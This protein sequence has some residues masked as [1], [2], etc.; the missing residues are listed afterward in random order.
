MPGEARFSRARS[1]ASRLHDLPHEILTAEQITSRFPA[2]R[3]PTAVSGV[4][5]PDGGFLD[6]ERCIAAHLPLAQAHG[7]ETPHGEQ[8]LAWEPDGDGVL[9]HTDQG[10]PTGA[11]RLVITAGAVAAEA[12]A[13]ARPPCGARAPG[14]G[15][16]PDPG[17]PSSSQPAS[18]RAS[19]SIPG[20]APTTGSRCTACPAS[21]WPATT[22]SAR[23]SIRTRWTARHAARTRQMS[24]RRCATPTSPTARAKRWRSRPASTPTRRIGHFIVDFHPELSAGRDRRR[25]LGARFQVLQRHRGDPG[26]SRPLG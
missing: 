19:S 15:V 23:W 24:A 25:V 6:P 10:R 26:R 12:G 8:I 11:D 18:S 5:Q 22:I 16:V 13:V 9:V 3:L 1:L 7:A 14:V 2:F 17:A 21:K 20:R 4:W